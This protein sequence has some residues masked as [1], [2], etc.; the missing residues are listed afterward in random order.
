LPLS[1]FLSFSVGLVGVVERGDMSSP[2]ASRPS[3]TNGVEMDDYYRRILSLNDEELEH[4]VREWV[5]RKS[6]AYVECAQFS[7]AGDLGRDVV[8]FLSR[9]RHQGEWHNYQCKQYSRTLPTADGLRE[10]GKILYHSHRGEFTAPAKYLFVAPKGVNRNLERLIFNPSL[11]K[12]K[13]ISAWDEYCADHIVEGQCVT[14]SNDLKTFIEAYDFSRIHRLKIDDLLADADITPVL[15]KWFGADPGPAPKGVVP[16]EIQESEL[17]YIGE[18]IDAYADRDG[19]PYKNVDSVAE[20]PAHSAHLARQRERFHDAEAF[21]R[22]YRD[23][24]DK[25]VTQAFEHDIYHGVADVCHAGHPDKL[26]CVDAVMRQAASV[27]TSGPL[28]PHARVPV[29][30]GLCHH[31]VNERRLKWRR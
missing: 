30:Q 6:S 7:G 19:K 1:Y 23:N 9:A 26:A 11:L 18:L 12:E 27:I 16:S 5:G 3:L 14:L 22:F 4:F 20:H 8:G 17:V 2:G 31:F 15:A 10:I 28:T 21:K 13:L 25:E 29:K 24:T